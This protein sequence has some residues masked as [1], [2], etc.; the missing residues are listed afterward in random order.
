MNPLGLGKRAIP[1]IE[2]VQNLLIGDFL[3]YMALHQGMF[4]PNMSDDVKKK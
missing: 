2:K 4:L 1:L 3:N